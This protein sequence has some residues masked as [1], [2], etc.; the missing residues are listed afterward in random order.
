MQPFET[1]HSRA[2]PMLQSDIDTDVIL[3]AR[4][5]LLMSKDGLGDKLCHDTRKGDGAP[6]AILEDTH[7]QGASILVTGERFGIGSS[8]EQAVWALY[9]Y[10]IRCVIAASFGEIF[11]ANCI[12]N[13]IVPIALTNAALSRVREA[14][15]SLHEI[16]V[17]V[18]AQCITLPEGEAIAIALTSSARSALLS[19]QDPIDRIL[20]YHKEDIRNFEGVQASKAPWFPLSRSDFTFLTSAAEIEE[21]RK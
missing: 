17:N 9:D 6:H 16:S 5:L 10:G 1:L 11:E 21:R 13:G 14:A 8:R 7:Y 3:P 15:L 2:I 20:D 4:F 12:N 19:G 18:E